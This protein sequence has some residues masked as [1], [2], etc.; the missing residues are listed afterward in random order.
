MKGTNK[1]M[2]K[3]REKIIE[4]LP[5]YKDFS[6]HKDLVAFTVSAEFVVDKEDIPDFAFVNV[7]VEKDWLFELMQQNG[8]ADPRQQ[9]EEEFIWDGSIEWFEAAKCFNKIA[10]IEFI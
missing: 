6:K 5:I 4:S 9:L 8:F 10:M 3:A 7:A 1:A 2:N